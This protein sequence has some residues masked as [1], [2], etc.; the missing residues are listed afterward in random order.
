MFG[1]S[2][3]VCCGPRCGAEPGHRV[4]YAAVEAAAPDGIL[5]RPT[6][7][8]GLCGLGVTIVLPDGEKRKIREAGEAA[9]LFV[10]ALPAL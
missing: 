1:P 2:V 4:L 8:Q 10:E 9:A 6:M 5:V 3:K 7:C